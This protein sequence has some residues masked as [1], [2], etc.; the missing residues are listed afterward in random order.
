MQFF[1]INFLIVTNYNVLNGAKIRVLLILVSL[2]YT[3][4]TTTV[5]SKSQNDTQL[6]QK[7][8]LFPF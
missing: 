7:Y 6:A 5:T 3:E 2:S 4:N 1:E 8:Q